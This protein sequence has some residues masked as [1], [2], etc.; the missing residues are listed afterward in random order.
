[1]NR[2]I[3]TVTFVWF[4]TLLAAQQA[5]QPDSAPIYHV[6]VVSRTLAA[7]NYQHRSGPTKIDFKGTVLL[8]AAHGEARIE[9]KKGRIDIDCKFVHIE[10]PQRFGP[11]YL[12]YVLWA[13]TP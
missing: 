7:V 9:S 8:P 5:P 10:A 11:G 1:M 2:L 6:T 4:C 3:T 13:I 12:T